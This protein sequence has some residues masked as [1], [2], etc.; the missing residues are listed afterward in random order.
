VYIPTPVVTV[1]VPCVTAVPCVPAPVVG[2]FDTPIAIE[3]IPPVVLN[4]AAAQSGGAPIV[5]ADYV[6]NAV[7]T[8]YDVHVAGP[9]NT[10]R[11]MRFGLNGGFYGFI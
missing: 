2:Y 11:T 5:S 6:H 7:G 9:Y 1:G 4:N 8:Y 3:Q 10:I